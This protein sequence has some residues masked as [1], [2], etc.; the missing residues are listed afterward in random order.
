VIRH[1]EDEQTLTAIRKKVN[2]KMKSFP[3]Y[4]EW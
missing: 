4:P 2:D 3:L 1:A